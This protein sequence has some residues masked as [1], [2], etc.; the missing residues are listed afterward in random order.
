MPNTTRVRKSSIQIDLEVKKRRNE[1]QL[2]GYLFQKVLAIALGFDLGWCKPELDWL[3]Y[4][5]IFSLPLVQKQLR[6]WHLNHDR[7]SYHLKGE[8]IWNWNK[9]Q[10]INLITSLHQNLI[11]SK[12]CLIGTIQ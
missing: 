6:R 3:L 4:W 11:D 2:L 1:T 7:S 8:S 5:I 9:L 10:Q 12:I